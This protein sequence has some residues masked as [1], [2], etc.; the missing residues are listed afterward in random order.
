MCRLLFDVTRLVESGLHTGIQR[1]V[2]SLLAASRQRFVP[3]GVEVWPVAFDG[4][5]W[6]RYS[7][8]APHP[9]QGVSASP[10]PQAFTFEP[11]AGDVLL[12]CD[13]SWYLDPWPAVAVAQQNGARLV[14]MVHDLLP[15]ERASWFRQGLQSR[16]A[17]HLQQLA[18]RADL[19]LTPSASVRGRLQAF[20]AQQG[21]E[22]Q[23][24]VLA[25]GGDF[26]DEAA[27]DI[28]W[29]EALAGVLQR[30]GHTPFYL[31]LGTLEPRKNHAQVLDAFESLWGADHDVG[32]LC[33]GQVGWQVE[34]LLGRL[35]QH[36]QW[37]RRLFHLEKVDDPTLARLLRRASALVFLSRDEGFGLPVLEAAMLGCPVIASDLPVLREAGGPWPCYVPL[38]DP[39]ALLDALRTPPSSLPGRAFS[40]R[41]DEVAARLEQLLGLTKSSPTS[42]SNPC[43]ERSP[44]HAT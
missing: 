23:T 14:G 30:I 13:A 2:R 42:L 43:S 41:W 29:P 7:H 5:N 10:Q 17:H 38:D 33:V 1:V 6:L 26:S 11:G 22:R 32:L 40:R 8:L 37:Q 20:L 3:Q 31:M 21:I 12:M 9:L 36:P 24:A 27:P 15:L 4:R 35:H 39:H 19:L 34:G 25:L 16:F 18:E 28:G 44:L